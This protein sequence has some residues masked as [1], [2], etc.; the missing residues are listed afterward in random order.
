M[1]GKSGIPPAKVI[2][3][4]FTFFAALVSYLFLRKIALRSAI[5]PSSLSNLDEVTTDHF[6]LN[7]TI[8]F[9]NKKISGSNTLS[10]R[11]LSYSLDRVNLDI[12]GLNIFSVT[13]EHGAQLN[14]DI[15]DV[16]HM[17]D[18][19]GLQL[20][21]RLAKVYSVGDTFK[22]TVN[23]ET[24]D[25]SKAFS[26]LNPEQTAGKK[27]PYLFTQCEPIYCRSLAPLQDSPSVKSTYT[28]DLRVPAPLMAYMSGNLTKYTPGRTYNY[29]TF[30][31]SIP[32]P[33]YLLAI[34]AGNVAQKQT[35]AR[36]YVITE[37]EMLQAVYYEFEE[38]ESFLVAVESYIL[39]YAWGVYKIVVLPPSFPYGGMENPLL[40]FA[41]PTL[42]VGDRSQTTVV[43]HEMAHSWTGNTITCRNWQSFWINEGLTVFLER[44][45][46]L[47]IK[48]QDFFRL[49]AYVGYQGL[50]EA[51]NNYGQNSNFTSLTP[52]LKNRNPDDAF[53]P[54]PYEKG[55][56][57]ASY[58]ESVVGAD[59]F[60]AFLRYFISKYRYQSVESSDFQQE[61]IAFIKGTKAASKLNE[62]NWK[63]WLEA[64]GIPTKT[65]DFTTH[66]I[67]DATALADEFIK[68][69]GS[70]PSD[71]D[72]WKDFE[73]NQK[74][75]HLNH[76]LAN[77]DKINV[78]VLQ[79]HYEVYAQDLGGKNAEIFTPWIRSCI[80]LGF[81]QRF[82]EMQYFLSNVGRMKY[83]RPIYQTL[84]AAKQRDL[85][86]TIF[87][88]NENFYHPIA[89][90][91][92]RKDLGITSG[93]EDE[94]ILNVEASRDSRVTY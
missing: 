5:D 18:V 31:S 78:A 23:Y 49:D 50:L 7:W 11:S 37:P 44:K 65:I 73:S 29:L 87:K 76:I 74:V 16:N 53:S 43:T 3:V 56:Q 52:L 82:Q 2:L 30:E 9:S 71:S 48:G 34:V 33:S 12:Q 88:Q 85:A 57:F 38:M 47:S 89:A 36:T 84:V 60:Q 67:D 51:I 20:Q 8:D 6:Y 25:K 35:G 81:T 28:A 93:S 24:T 45:G 54:V 41:S 39:P 66:L 15:V 68:A 46:D 69:A 79:A 59:N 61:F 62:V 80:F 40:T 19:L 75:I 55:F 21:V 42:I 70:V 90:A 64:P 4:A 91:L 32:I 72:K 86:I 94:V 27:Y 14:Y 17:A 58:L 13:D 83:I 22:L 63:V 1:T 10:F 26:W 92:I 77:K